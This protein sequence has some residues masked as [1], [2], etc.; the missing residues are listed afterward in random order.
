[1]LAFTIRIGR[2]IA[3]VGFGRIKRYPNGS[4]VLFSWLNECGAASLEI[5]CCTFEFIREETLEPRFDM[6]AVNAAYAALVDDCDQ[7][8]KMQREFTAPRFESN[9]DTGEFSYH[10]GSPATRSVDSWGL[11]Q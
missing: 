2:Y 10:P 4:P 11:Y 9:D 3:S 8:A 6:E 7:L 5:P 1:M